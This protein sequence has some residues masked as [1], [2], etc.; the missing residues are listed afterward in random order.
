M[1]IA[2]IHANWIEMESHMKDMI[3][4]CSECEKYFGR[5]DL[6]KQHMVSHTRE[7][8]YICVQC[9]KSFGPG[10]S[11]KTHMLTHSGLKTHTCSECKKSFGEAGTLR[12]H[13]ITHTGEQVHKCAECG[14]L[15]IYLV[16]LENWKGTC[17][18]TVERSHT[19]AHNAIMHL[20]K[21]A[22]LES[23]SKDI[24]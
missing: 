2:P 16:T 12:K 15:G 11:L 8:A 4:I 7:R 21:P 9:H 23:T 20:H 10:G 22:I 19:N 18:S 17:S 1:G 13:K 3:H 14:D 5:A 6:L 24:P